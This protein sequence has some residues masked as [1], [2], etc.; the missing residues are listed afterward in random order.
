MT[1]LSTKKNNFDFR[2]L[3]DFLPDNYIVFEAIDE[4]T[5]ELLFALFHVSGNN[6]KMIT[7]KYDFKLK[8]P[9]NPGEIYKFTVKK[10]E[11]T[12]TI[13]VSA[14]RMNLT[15][16]PET[17]PQN[18]LF[19]IGNSVAGTTYVLFGFDD[20][21]TMTDESLLD[22]LKGFADRHKLVLG[23]V[24]TP[25]W[26]EKL[27]RGELNDFAIITADGKKVR[28]DIVPNKFIPLS[29]HFMLKPKTQVFPGGQKG[30]LFFYFIAAFIVFYFYILKR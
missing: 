14:F 26:R 29:S 23:E 16:Y 27:R 18:I 15:V 1:N 4:K 9:L 7:T 12:N 13:N 10:N 28:G 6:F 19:R 3:Y 21:N 11:I 5:Y 17:M 20:T 25:N 2:F 22:S 24:V 30:L 8:E